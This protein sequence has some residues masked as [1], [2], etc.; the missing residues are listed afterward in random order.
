MALF[1]KSAKSL[2]ADQIRSDAAA[3]ADSLAEQA[4]RAA[5]W[6]APRVVRARHSVT[7]VARGAQD[8]LEPA[9]E[10]ARSRVVDDYLPRAQRAAAA[11]QAAAHTPGSVT[12]RAQ[13]V[14]V[15]ARQAAVEAP[16]PRKSHRFLKTLGWLAVAG[17]AS[18]A[19]YVV[20]RRSQPVED[21]WAEE[22]WADS[23]SDLTEVVDEAQNEA[24]D[25]IDD[26]RDKAAE[27]AD[28]AAEEVAD[29]A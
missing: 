4:E 6:V 3:L 11:A 7:R 25:V 12:E 5:E 8:R 20:W 15:A 24:A 2:D 16:Q 28:Q 27:A 21:P 9:Y 19:A 23:G 26:A 22:Y 14:A 17:A 10:G 1:K 13:R 29:K 18:T